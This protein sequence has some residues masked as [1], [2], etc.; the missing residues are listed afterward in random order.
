VHIA[1]RIAD[2]AEAG[3]ILVSR[4]VRDLAVG[5]PIQFAEHG[6]HTLRGVPEPWQLYA[7]ES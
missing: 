3:E 7:V 4:T 2:R 1:S 5:A 6:T